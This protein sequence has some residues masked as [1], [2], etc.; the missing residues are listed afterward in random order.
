M[1]RMRS[2]EDIQPLTAFRA[3]VA[4]FVDQVRQ[5]GRPLILTQHGRSSAVL[6]SAT[7]YEALLDELDT[8]RD[9][10]A[11]EDQIARGEGI[12]H[13]EVAH[14]LRARVRGRTRR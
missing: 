8:L 2:T 14:D 3:N 9:V 11:S 12:A 4:A 1:P 6:M 13:D 10:K 7:E 5:T